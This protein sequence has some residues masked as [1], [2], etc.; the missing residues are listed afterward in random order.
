[1]TKLDQLVL[2][3]RTWQLVHKHCVPLSVTSVPFVITQQAGCAFKPGTRCLTVEIDLVTSM[4]HGELTAAVVD[5]I[6]DAI[7]TVVSTYEQPP[8][9]PAELK[10]LEEPVAAERRQPNHS[11]ADAGVCAR[12]CYTTSMCVCCFGRHVVRCPL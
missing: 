3:T 4:R 9:Q 1:M 6:A 5:N 2:P 8:L 11:R 12:V 10:F 7:S